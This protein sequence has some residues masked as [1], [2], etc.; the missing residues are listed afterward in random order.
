M[1]LSGPSE[2]EASLAQY[3][4]ALTLD[5]GHVGALIACGRKLLTLER[6]A[7]AGRYLLAA[8][9]RQQHNPAAWSAPLPVLVAA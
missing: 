7:M 4:K 6:T 3:S 8:V 5:P 1:D 9:N 2:S